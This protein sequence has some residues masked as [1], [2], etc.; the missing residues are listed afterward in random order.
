[1][2]PR[3]PFIEYANSLDKVIIWTSLRRNAIDW[4][5]AIFW[6][7]FFQVEVLSRSWSNT[8]LF[9]WMIIFLVIILCCKHNRCTTSLKLL[10]VLV[11]IYKSTGKNIV[12]PFT[13]LSVGN[14]LS[15]FFKI[16]WYLILRYPENF[17]SW[18]L[19]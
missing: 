17:L 14:L 10:F 11:L 19:P 12:N 1:M 7:V 8:Y 9:L 4:R 15:L 2:S 18:R 3:F 13:S 5:K 16:C 6:S